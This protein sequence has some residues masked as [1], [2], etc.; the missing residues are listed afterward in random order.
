MGV[1]VAV[2]PLYVHR[3]CSTILNTI[4]SSGAV[5]LSEESHS[6]PCSCIPRAPYVKTHHLDTEHIRTYPDFKMLIRAKVIFICI[7]FSSKLTQAVDAGEAVHSGTRFLTLNN[8][9][10]DDSGLLHRTVRSVDEDNLSDTEVHQIVDGH[11]A[12]RRGEGA[13]NMEYMVCHSYM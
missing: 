10:R 9:R 8:E 3:I 5:Y 11:N 12:Y 4:V 13:S 7:I 1:S 6:C 2:C